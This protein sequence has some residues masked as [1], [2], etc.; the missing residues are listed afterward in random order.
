MKRVPLE[1]ITARDAG[2]ASAMISRDAC[3]AHAA[4]N[5]VV[6]HDVAR[7]VP[8]VSL[9]AVLG[10]AA[11]AG[12]LLAVSLTVAGPA[13]AQRAASSFPKSTAPKF[14]APTKIDRSKPL[15]LTADELVYD[16]TG[17]RIL[18][19][20]N[21]E[22][23]YSD[24]SL[25]A[26]EVVYDQG[27]KTIIANGNVTIRDPNGGIWRGGAIEL[28][29][30]FRE[31]F[32]ESLSLVGTDNTR[33]QARRAVRKDGNVTEFT[34]GQY[35]PCTTDSN[36][37]PLWCIGAARIV[38]DQKAQTIS[39]QDAQ[40]RF[41]GIPIAWM[42]Y[43]EHAD[44]TVKRRSGFLMPDF[45][46][47]TTLGFGVSTPYYFAL[48]P[49]Y[50]FLFSPEYLSKQGVLWKG[51]WRHRLAGGQYE[52]KAA[53]IEQDF[54]D[55][56]GEDRKLDGW[57]GS[58]ATKGMFSLSSW[59][60][61]GWDVTVESDDTFR[62]FYKLDNILLTDRV[63]EVFAEG[64]S[65]RNYF[66]ARLYQ[67]GGLLLSDTA[68]SE[69]RAHPVIDHDYVFA[70]PVLG[71]ELSFKNNALSLSRDDAV[72]KRIDQ[73][74]T[75]V[76]SEAKWRRKMTDAL[77][78]TYTPYGEIRGDVFYYDNYVDPDTGQ[79]ITNET[80]TRA[81]ATGGVTVSYP[82]VANSRGGSHVIEPIGQVYVSQA[83]V[84]QRKLPNEDARSLIFDDSNLFETQKFSG[85]DR[86][87]TGTRA[88]VGIQ[89][90]FQSNTGGYARFLAGQ[91]YHFA[92]DNAYADTTQE[93]V[94]N[95]VSGQPQK[96]FLF[97]PSSGLE[98]SRSDYLLGAYLAPSDMF[99]VL[100]QT[101]F[102]ENDVSLRRQDLYASFNY[103]PVFATAVYT[104]AA[105]DP[106]LGFET[107]QQDVLGVLGLKLTDRWSLIGT[108]RYDLDVRQILT[109]SISLRYADDCFVLTTT[110]QET[111][112]ENAALGLQED[113]TL[114]LRFELK[115]IGSF[116]YQTSVLDTLG[117]QQRP[118]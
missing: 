93:T 10:L 49:Q 87:E 70:D 105:A 88:N 84:S 12:A 56:P 11:A 40:F 100:S 106:L 112:L 111:F 19:R 68:A 3:R 83:S 37:P 96:Q 9:S 99:R 104:Y 86:V 94:V 52:I 25:T 17:N 69:S 46:N 30:D 29:D 108:V 82:W 67:F 5:S 109:D 45:S 73:S 57:R 32:I 36:M 62:K 28:S 90:T 50:D 53:G 35:T 27:S 58:V 64:L 77:G 103:G 60:R 72:A 51:H 4:A 26:D 98:S 65:G 23:Y 107:S 80:S 48:S 13:S 22:L 21:V 24:Y 39:Y 89:Y 20:G 115:N 43:F 71:G 16:N 47:S 38:H 61:F 18:A 8:T 34:D 2:R 79:T 41:L 114:M 63:N 110:Y 101:R 78:I 97:S 117:D 92:G 54:R 74:Y 95:P 116:G 118:R 81:L 31:G 76:R 55:V 6:A 44:P 15:N 66:G 75:H 91:H 7:V 14:S 113:R 33:I 1:P 102:D 59:W 85:S 42:P